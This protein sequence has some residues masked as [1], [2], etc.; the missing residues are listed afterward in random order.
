MPRVV[1]IMIGIAAQDTSGKPVVNMGKAI[2][3][4][5]DADGAVGSFAAPALHAEV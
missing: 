2:L 3:V 1:W 5:L 4:F